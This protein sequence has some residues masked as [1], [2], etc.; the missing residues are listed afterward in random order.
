VKHFIVGAGPDPGFPRRVAVAAYSCRR[1]HSPKHAGKKSAPWPSAAGA[2]RDVLHRRRGASSLCG[3]AREEGF[4][5]RPVLLLMA[6]G[7][8]VRTL[9]GSSST[10][11]NDIT[12]MD[13]TAKPC[14]NIL[15]SS[16]FL[17]YASNYHF[18][19]EAFERLPSL[20]KLLGRFL[21]K[22]LAQPGHGVIQRKKMS[23][24]CGLLLLSGVVV[25]LS[26][27]S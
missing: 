8:S 6:A 27:P 12:S 19:A 2:R 21:R 22:S 23:R 25:M 26:P 24:T 3:R 9:A 15:Q 1:R 17:N 5:G 4:F 10:A 13:T 11:S 16:N 14:L 7:C 20:R 18:A